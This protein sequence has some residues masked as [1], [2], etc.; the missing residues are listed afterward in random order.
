[1]IIN[2]YRELEE[3]FEMFKKQNADLII[4]VSKAG[5]GKTTTFKK[6]MGKKKHVYISIHST[7]LRT[8]K[9]LYENKNRP[10]CIDDLDSIT[11]PTMVALFKCLADTT[12]QKEIHWGTTSRLLGEVPEKFKTESNL[13]ILVNQ[14]NINNPLL[15]PLVNRGFDLRFEPS[16]LE[17]LKKI[18]EIAKS[19]NLTKSEKQVLEFI[20]KHYEEIKDF[21]LRT[22]IKALQLFR[23]NK[24]K[25][26]ERFMKMVSFDEKKIA[27]ILLLEK[28]KTDKE[29]IKEFEKRWSRATFYRIKT[30]L[31]E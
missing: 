11:N 26:K 23:D 3:F 24:K 13:C 9:K 14:F 16:N 31:K 19:Q 5:L 8:Y 10:V 15:V 29:R 18:R 20:E 25:W 21:S 2:T 17:I 28:Y 22:Y 4:F 6:I 27:V 30:G 12:P 7:P 1:M